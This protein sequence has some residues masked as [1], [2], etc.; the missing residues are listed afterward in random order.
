[1]ATR[2]NFPGP[3]T[4]CNSNN[5]KL[6]CVTITEPVTCEGLTV[7][8]A[9]NHRTDRNC[10]VTTNCTSKPSTNNS[11]SRTNNNTELDSI[12][13]SLG[14]VI[15]LLALLEIAT[16]IGCLLCM[17]RIKG[18]SHQ[19]RYAAKQTELCKIN[20][21]SIYIVSMCRTIP[22]VS[23]HKPKS[24]LTLERD[25]VVVLSNT[26]N[27]ITNKAGEAIVGYEPVLPRNEIIDSY[28]TIATAHDGVNEYDT[29][30]VKEETIEGYETE[31][32][33]NDDI[34]SY[35]YIVSR[36]NPPPKISPYR[37]NSPPAVGGVNE[38][39]PAHYIYAEVNKKGKTSAVQQ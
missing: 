19:K 26:V 38:D 6:S 37:P 15:G 36:K 18:Y 25:I 39:N 24:T 34:A 4:N 30:G 14:A 8:C 3:K 13:I 2:I 10:T 28:E 22:P 21:L 33:N 31:N 23:Y 12:I 20:T 29:V 11:D 17:A 5:T 32:N 27:N 1:M 7:H 16:V 9:K 35:D